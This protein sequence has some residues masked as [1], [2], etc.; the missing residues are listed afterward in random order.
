[1]TNKLIETIVAIVKQCNQQ[2]LTYGRFVINE[3]KLR[4]V[5]ENEKAFSD[6]NIVKAIE[7]FYEAE[8]AAIEAE[9]TK[10]AASARLSQ[11]DKVKKAA[12]DFAS[13]AAIA[14]AAAKAAREAQQRLQETAG[15]D[16]N[17]ALRMAI[18]DSMTDTE[19]QQEDED[20]QPGNQ[21]QQDDN[22]AKARIKK[23]K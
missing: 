21:F 17:E 10:A 14:D 8:A 19:Q 13:A 15:V 7:D 4:S 2:D 20:N 5:L 12:A 16:A 6:A 23:N 11:D 3:I 18:K 9:K 22:I 1:M